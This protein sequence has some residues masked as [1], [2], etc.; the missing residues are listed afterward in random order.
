MFRVGFGLGMEDADDALAVPNGAAGKRR[1]EDGCT[2]HRQERFF[3][4]LYEFS[5][6]LKNQKSVVERRI[7][8]PFA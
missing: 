4:V 8:Y 6:F 5:F 7:R 2:Q 3:Q 1:A